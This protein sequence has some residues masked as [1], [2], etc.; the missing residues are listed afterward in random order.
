MVLVVLAVFLLSVRVVVVLDTL[1]SVVVGWVGLI[2][3]WFV[4][5]GLVVLVLLAL[6]VTAVLDGF[7]FFDLPWPILIGGVV[8]ILGGIDNNGKMGGSGN[9]DLHVTTQ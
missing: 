8:F 3:C 9:S 6:V 5:L 1:E 4:V 2:T 7:L